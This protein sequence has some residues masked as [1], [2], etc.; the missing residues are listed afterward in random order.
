M[1]IVA[2]APVR[3]DLA[4]G[5]T[6]VH[7]FTE[8]Y[9]GEVVNLAISMHA[10][11]TLTIDGDGLLS[12]SYS[13]AAPVG[14]GL[15]TT[16]AINVALAAVIRA[17]GIDSDLRP[18]WPDHDDRVDIAERAFEIEAALGNKGGRQDQWAASLGGWNHLMF[19]G[20][21]VETLPFE[22]RRSACAWLQRHLVLADCGEA[23]VSGDLHNRIWDRFEAGDDEVEKALI[24]IRR[25]ARTM[26]DGLQQDRRDRVVEAF[27][28]VCTAIDLKAPELH[29]P[30]R[31][32]TDQLSAAGA[33]AG[34]KALGAGGGGVA[35]L[36]CTPTG[37]ETVQQACEAA[38]WDTFDWSPD[39]N[40]LVLSFE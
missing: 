36:L 40:G 35:A 17:A 3:I 15:G 22:P 9:G 27:S 28:E 32:V 38:G 14:S 4:G 1:R 29:D 2:K 7:P 10:T 6:D 16:G 12:T 37:R 8:R 24:K 23:H 5:W 33:I 19:V 34:W 20:D 18:S 30:F 31:S 39:E 21:E 11:A 13:C 26:A 25:A